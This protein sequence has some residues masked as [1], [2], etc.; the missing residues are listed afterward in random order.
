MHSTL[1]RETRAR[2]DWCDITTDVQQA[3]AAS[4]RDE[5]LA[6]VFVPHTT[7]AVTIQ[8]NA[9]PPLKRDITRAL[10]RIFPWEDEYGHAE[11]N[12]AA[13]LKVVAMGPSVQVP[14]AGG[15]LLLGTWQ[16]I[17]LCEFDGPRHRQI[18]VHVGP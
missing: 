10:D 12:A 8:E 11:G 17:Y 2:N 4:G 13:H 3:V 9:D 18:V 14:F 15:R 6:T 7:A 1:T 16:A 5:G